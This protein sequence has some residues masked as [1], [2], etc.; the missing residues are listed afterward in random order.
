MRLQPAGSSPFVTHAP[1]GATARRAE[2]RSQRRCSA[3][4]G[5][6]IFSSTPRVEDFLIVRADRNRG[7]GVDLVIDAQG[8]AK[9]PV[10]P[11]AGGTCRGLRLRW[12]SELPFAGR[13]GLGSTTGPAVSCTI[14]APFVD[15]LRRR[16]WRPLRCRRRRRVLGVRQGQGVAIALDWG[17][18]HASRLDPL[19]DA[20]PP[21]QLLT[22]DLDRDVGGERVRARLACAC[23]TWTGPGS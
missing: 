6:W 9:R 17:Q 23:H 10:R 13:A 12:T 11:W 7:D 22:D 8:Q 20:L 4:G 19:S 5:R 14:A 18:G 16:L 21:L 3:A 1:V 2:A 15:G